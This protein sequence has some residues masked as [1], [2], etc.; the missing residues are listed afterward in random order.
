MYFVLMRHFRWLTPRTV[1]RLNAN[2]YKCVE[3]AMDSSS[4]DRT[5]DEEM[6]LACVIDIY[7]LFAL[8]SPVTYHDVMMCIF[9]QVWIL[10]FA[11]ETKS[12]ETYNRQTNPW[13]SPNGVSLSDP[14]VPTPK[15]PKRCSSGSLQ[16]TTVNKHTYYYNGLASSLYY[17]VHSVG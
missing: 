15:C 6:H 7:D 8:H 12:L 13:A 5:L 4:L 11:K 10:D 1:I 17:T 14:N 2:Y 9:S 16:T 3:T